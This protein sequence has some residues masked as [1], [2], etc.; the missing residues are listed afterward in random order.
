MASKRPSY[1]SIRARQKN[2]IEGLGTSDLKYAQAAKRFG[3]EPRELRKFVT[4]K[5]K[6]LRRNFNRSASYNKLYG[7]GK[8]A[9]EQRGE[10]RENLG[11]KR[12]KRYAIRKEDVKAIV[13]SKRYNPAETENRV[14][15]G[16]ILQNLYYKGEQAQTEWASYTREHGLPN[17]IQ[18][19]RLL[20]QNDRISGPDY[21]NAL[22]QWK[23]IYNISDAI[24]SRYED[25]LS[26]YD[27]VA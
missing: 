10:V 23:A 11:V 15:I 6:N 12:I 24:Y 19:L 25:E 13:S 14:Q 3:V 1:V 2:I 9:S 27:E 5:P 16:K 22:A 21:A 4:T 18:V 7:K 20:Y 17:S 8:T 26:E